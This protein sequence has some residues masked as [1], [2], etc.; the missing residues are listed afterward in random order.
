MTNYIGVPKT[1]NDPLHVYLSTACLHEN[2]EHCQAETNP[3]GEERFPGPASGAERRASA[4][5]T[6]HK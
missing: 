3:Q 2:H 5:V 4:P 1:R 6:A